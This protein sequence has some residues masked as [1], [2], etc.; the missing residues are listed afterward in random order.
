MPLQLFIKN[1]IQ[2]AFD[3]CR[4]PGYP[5][6]PMPLTHLPREYNIALRIRERNIGDNK[7]TFIVRLLF[8]ARRKRMESACGWLFL[9]WAL[10]YFPFYSMGR[11]LYFH[12]YFPAYLYSAMLAGQYTHNRAET[13]QPARPSSFF[14]LLFHT[15]RK[16]EPLKTDVLAGLKL[17]CNRA[18]LE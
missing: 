4:G 11:V 7:Y 15:P 16:Q 2:Q 10:H 17:T 3:H 12:H 1:V 8:T 9:G 13:D 5:H 18:F 6:Q 14:L